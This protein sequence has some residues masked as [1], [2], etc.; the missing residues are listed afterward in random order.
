MRPII[1]VT[2]AMDTCYAE[3]VTAVAVVMDKKGPT[4]KKDEVVARAREAMGK[5]SDQDQR[6]RLLESVA[7]HPDEKYRRAAFL[8]LAPE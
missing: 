7:R 4:K 1:F 6:R 5:V 8:L 3:G 2:A